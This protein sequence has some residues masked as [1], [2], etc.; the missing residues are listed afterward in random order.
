MKKRFAP[1]LRSFAS[2]LNRISD[3]LER[4][5]SQ[6][7]RYGTHRNLYR[8]PTG[9]LLWLN[10]TGYLDRMIIR[11]G[12]FE[13]MSTAAVNRL[14]KPGFTVLDIGANIGYYTVIASKLVSDAGKVIAFE[15]TVNFLD[16]LSKNIAAN[17]LSNVEVMPYGLSNRTCELE[18]DIGPSSATLHS[19]PGF[20]KVLSTEKIQLISLVDFVQTSKIE[21]IDFIKIDIDGHEPVFFEGAWPILDAMSP[22]ILCEVSHL[23]YLQAGYT[24]WDF[25]SKVKEHN[26]KIYE[27][28]NL[29]EIT[30]KEM[31]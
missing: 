14:V 10:N 21:K 7:V 18:I 26:Y 20:D 27:E 1:Y 16:V 12:E 25:Y 17:N 3:E 11:E 6:L 2:Y 5:G 28:S 24:A 29:D 31:F 23:H 8:T 9:I 13:P 4:G 15:P 30:T 19:P 22:I